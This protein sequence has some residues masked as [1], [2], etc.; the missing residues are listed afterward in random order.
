VSGEESPRSARVSTVATLA[1]GLFLTSEVASF[2]KIGRR[3]AYDR[4]K[5]RPG[6][7][8]PGATATAT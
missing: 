6:S 2:E 1:E 3:D 8:G 5:R 4:C 7:R